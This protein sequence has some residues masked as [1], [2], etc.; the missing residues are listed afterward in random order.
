LRIAGV[1]FAAVLLFAIYWSA[2]FAYADDLSRKPSLADA[3]AAV[4]LAPLNASYWLRWADLAE[5]SGDSG[6][7]SLQ[8]AL[9][10][11]P[12]YAPAWIRAGLEAE[13]AGDFVRAEHCLLRASQ[14]SHM[15]EP[16][17]ALADYYFRRGNESEFW[18]WMKS[19]LEWSSGDRRPLYDLCWRFRPEPE[20]ILA[21]G[22]PAKHELMLD[23]LVYLL[24]AGRLDAAESM[25]NRLMHAGGLRRG[26]APDEEAALLTYT[27][28]MLV[29]HRWDSAMVSWK[30]LGYPGPGLTNG[31]FTTAFLQRGF[32]WRTPEAPGVTVLRESDPPALRIDFSGKQPERCEILQQFVP[33]RPGTAYRLSF[34]YTASDIAPHSGLAWRAFDPDTGTE[35]PLNSPQLSTSQWTGAT[36]L[37]VAP[38]RA[39]SLFLALTYV[40]ESG[41]VRIEGSASLRN[42]GIREV[43][44]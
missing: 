4:R 18:R 14:A 3:A 26:K 29:A 19:A 25:G 44:P 27:D 17:W 16:R 41:T 2:R 20:T 8:H 21:R 23:Y 1:T 13:A 34:E 33:V 35:V 32:D 6:A 40:R 22:I 39:R 30:A 11:D 9:E 28:T 31:N 12:G 36:A 10:L 43:H 15:F 7:H 5:I 38:P 37:F 42:V 24:S